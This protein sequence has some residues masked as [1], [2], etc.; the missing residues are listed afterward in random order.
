MTSQDDTKLTVTSTL[1]S[2][3]VYE[4]AFDVYLIIQFIT[5]TNTTRFSVSGQLF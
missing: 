3:S 1:G 2:F 4:T 5:W